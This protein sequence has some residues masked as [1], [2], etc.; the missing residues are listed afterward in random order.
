LKCPRNFPRLPSERALAQQFGKYLLQRK[1]AEGGMAEVFLARQSG[2]EGFEKPVVIKR[3]LPHLSNEQQFI[4]MFLN[5]AKVA[6][7]LSHP[8]I[9]QIFDFG[10]VEGQY[11]IA[12]EFIHGEDLRNLAKWA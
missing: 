5:E 1:L 11:Y 6:A 2:M 7:R 4:D 8:A 10:K 12:M 3:I 9:V